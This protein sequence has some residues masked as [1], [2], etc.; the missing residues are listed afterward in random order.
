MAED[1]DFGS[2]NSALHNLRE[3]HEADVA[4]SPAV[5]RF[6]SA[7]GSGAQAPASTFPGTPVSFAGAPSA[8]TMKQNA[9]ASISSTK[10]SVRQSVTTAAVNIREEVEASVAAPIQTAASLTS[11]AA[12]VARSEFESRWR[13]VVL[14]EER[15]KALEEAVAKKEKQLSLILSRTT[16]NFPPRFLCI[17]PI[18]HH[19]IEQDIPEPRQK[20]VRMSYMNW[21]FTI[22]MLF[23]N[24]MLSLCLQFVETKV[25]DPSEGSQTG[26]GFLYFFL[27]SILSFVFWHWR[28]YLSCANGTSGTYVTAFI[29]IL[30]AMLFNAWM[31]IGVTGY[32][33]CGVFYLWYVKAQ[34]GS[35]AAIPVGICLALWIIQ[36]LVFLYSGFRLRTY[37][38][39]D[40][41]SLSAARAE[42]AADAS[43]VYVKHAL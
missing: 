24:F 20:F 16:P 4:S 11:A 32:G 5:T 7:P 22:F 27:G 36:G 23:F 37:F 6:G 3:R 43:K 17:K 21:F 2:V 29:G 39:E 31:V 30:L 26:L 15:L 28:I 42:L 8:A 40:K 34:K 1:E 19:V 14:E 13:N 10:Q 33:G 25:A 12:D 41:A 9:F 18:V 35:N 38:K